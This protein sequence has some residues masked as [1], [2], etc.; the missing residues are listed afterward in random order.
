M[1]SISRGILSPRWRIFLS[2][3][4]RVRSIGFRGTWSNESID[5]DIFH[6]LSLC[7]TTNVLFPNLQELAW[8]QSKDEMIPYIRLFGGPLTRLSLTVHGSGNLHLSL[9]SS[10]QVAYPSMHSF[11]LWWTPST[12]ASVKAVSDLVCRWDR[13]ENLSCGLLTEEAWAHISTLPTLQHLHAQL[14]DNFPSLLNVPRALDHG[15]LFT[16]LKSL[17]LRASCLTSCT[18]IMRLMSSSCMRT[19]WI[20]LRGNVKTVEFLEFFEAVHEHCP[21]SSLRSI[22]LSHI[23]GEVLPSD[24]R[25]ITMATIRP[26]LA[27]RNLTAV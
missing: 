24:D 26:L 17:H 22:T 9:L 12:D 4:A 21:H 8:S 6:A 23:S 27:F 5:T 14:P 16:S 7:P 1:H 10:L 3:A 19:I 11:H 18:T 13:L 2:Y 15:T 25:I 20:V